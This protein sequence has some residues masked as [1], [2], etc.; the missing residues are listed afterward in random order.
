MRTTLITASF[1]GA[2][3]AFREAFNETLSVRHSFQRIGSKSLVF[4]M[5]GGAYA[6]SSCS[7]ESFR[8]VNGPFN[9]VFGGVVAGTFY[10]LLI[11]DFKKGIYVSGSLAAGMAMYVAALLRFPDKNLSIEDCI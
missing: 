9:S 7:M 11:N 6:A 8:G 10:G 3:E 5:V 4:G 1:G 2:F